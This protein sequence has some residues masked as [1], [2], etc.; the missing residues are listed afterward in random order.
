[1]TTN[2]DPDDVRQRIN[3]LYAALLTERAARLE[4]E[5]QNLNGN[6]KRRGQRCAKPSR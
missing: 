1:M 2:L 4:A 5:S 3:D 6:G